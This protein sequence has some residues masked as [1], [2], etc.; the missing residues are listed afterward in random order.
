MVYFFAFMVLIK[1]AC[2]RFMAALGAPAGEEGVR[3]LPGKVDLFVVDK[4]SSYQ[5]ECRRMITCMRT[6]KERQMV[7][8]SLLA[9]M[10]WE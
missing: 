7:G 9:V 8:E 2:T 1:P 6:R 4:R 3:S 10:G 5:E